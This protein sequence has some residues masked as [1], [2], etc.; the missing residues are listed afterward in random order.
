L[1]IVRN[2]DALKRKNA[3]I[4]KLPLTHFLETLMEGLSE[5]QTMKEGKVETQTLKEGKVELL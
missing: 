4:T 3:K 2:S 5:T 1:K